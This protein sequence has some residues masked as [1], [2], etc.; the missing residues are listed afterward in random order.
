MHIEENRSTYVEFHADVVGNKVEVISEVKCGEYALQQEWKLQK[1]VVLG[2]SSKPQNVTING[3]PSTEVSI[4]NT[5]TSLT[6]GDLHLSQIYGTQLGLGI[7]TL[8]LDTTSSIVHNIGRK[9]HHG[10]DWKSRVL[11]AG[12]SSFSF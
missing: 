12:I 4:H 10:Y 7:T 1:I 11:Y 8:V 9:V 3:F 6:I 5:S 2:S